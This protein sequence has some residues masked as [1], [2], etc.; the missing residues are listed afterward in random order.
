[1]GCINKNEVIHS[2]LNDSE[3]IK[4]HFLKEAETNKEKINESQTNI[5]SKLNN[6]SKNKS[7]KNI[8]NVKLKEKKLTTSDNK[9][10]NNDLNDN[11]DNNSVNA[12]T[13]IDYDW[14][15]NKKFD[16]E[17]NIIKV[18]KKQNDSNDEFL[19]QSKKRFINFKIIE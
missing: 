11:N 16:E 3:Q 12:K 1:M 8:F 4:A 7:N 18:T 10:N 5:H 19:I 6:G 15:V 9:E 17:Y 13:N 14:I 2:K